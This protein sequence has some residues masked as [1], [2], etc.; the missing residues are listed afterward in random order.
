MAAPELV[1]AVGVVHRQAL[2]GYWPPM[3]RSRMRKNPWSTA[4]RQISHDPIL[5][6]SAGIDQ[7]A[8]QARKIPDLFAGIRR[9]HLLGLVWYDGGHAGLYHQDWQLPG[10]PAALAAFRRGVASMTSPGP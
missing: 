6:S 3:A 1:D 5:L 7:A 9:Y 8:G 2:S 10:D 4:C